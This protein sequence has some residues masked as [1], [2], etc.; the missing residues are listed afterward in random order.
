[1]VPLYLPD[2]PVL[3]REIEVVYK[4]LVCI[5]QEVPLDVNPLEGGPLVVEGS[6]VRYPQQH[7]ASFLM[8]IMSV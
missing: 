2:E 3:G 1:M 7:A 8:N 5:P 4:P 6:I